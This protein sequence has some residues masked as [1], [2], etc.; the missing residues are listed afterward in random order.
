MTTPLDPETV[1]IEFSVRGRLTVP[2]GTRAVLAH[3]GHVCKLLLP[4][5]TLLSV[6]AAFEAG[7]SDGNLSDEELSALG[8]HYDYDVVEL[9]PER[10]LPELSLDEAAA[11][12]TEPTSPAPYRVVTFNEMYSVS[13][14]D[15]A[16]VAAL[17]AHLATLPAPGERLLQLVTNERGVV[18]G[19]V[20]A[21]VGST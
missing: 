7:E 11:Q 14:F 3:Q 8:C 15:P 18:L 10:E 1:D 2:S 4:D 16:G 6:W 5:G 20:L 17:E 13:V 9:L 19:A 12:A 21:R